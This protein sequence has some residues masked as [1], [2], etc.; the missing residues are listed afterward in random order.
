[1][2]TLKD[3]L[4]MKKETTMLTILVDKRR[5]TGIYSMIIAS[6]INILEAYV[7][8]LL[9]TLMIGSS[10]RNQIK[11]SQVQ[12]KDSVQTEGKELQI[13]CKWKRKTSI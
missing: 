12:T 10:R 6:Y 8:G 9:D 2:H 1:M 3:V 11:E 7:T 13:M 5:L 4:A